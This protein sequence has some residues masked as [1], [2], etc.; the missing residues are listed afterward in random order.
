MNSLPDTVQGVS[1]TPFTS[2][3]SSITLD[4]SPTKDMKDIAQQVKQ[5]FPQFNY[6]QTIRW[7]KI[8]RN[9]GKVDMAKFA[10]ELLSAKG[11]PT[12]RM[13]DVLKELNIDAR[14]GNTESLNTSLSKTLRRDGKK[15]PVKKVKQVKSRTVSYTHLTL[16]TTD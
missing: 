10:Y 1:H 6:S 14:E 11:Y 7:G 2:D 5:Q 9:G 8:E 3:A 16:P 12:A 15:Q 13:V 4:K